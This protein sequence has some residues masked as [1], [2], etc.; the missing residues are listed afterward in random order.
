MG[1]KWAI[2]GLKDMTSRVRKFIRTYMRPETVWNCMDVIRDCIFEFL[3]TFTC[4]IRTNC[5]SQ[6]KLMIAVT[7]KKR[8]NK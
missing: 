2:D 7:I 6:L 3:V 4:K 1:P 8:M 5:R